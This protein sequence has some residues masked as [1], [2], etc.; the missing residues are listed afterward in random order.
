MTMLAAY[1]VWT[2]LALGLWFR[3]LVLPPV[4]L[5]GGLAVHASSSQP[6]SSFLVFAVLV[7]I[8][9]LAACLLKYLPQRSVAEA[10]RA[11]PETSR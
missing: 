5:V 1:A 11:L 4:I 9:Y 8:G 10:A 2:G 6:L 7:Q 3:V